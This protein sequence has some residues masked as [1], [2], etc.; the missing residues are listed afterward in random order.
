MF[1]DPNSNLCTCD[2]LENLCRL[3]IELLPEVAKRVRLEDLYVILKNCECG[4]DD[5]LEVVEE[6][7][8][9]YLC[10]DKDQVKAGPQDE[11][12]LDFPCE[13]LNDDCPLSVTVSQEDA[14][15]MD[16]STEA[17]IFAISKKCKNGIDNELEVLEE[18]ETYFLCQMKPIAK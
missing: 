7:E 3:E 13:C 16:A 4:V 8:D 17:A 2:C 1:C 18:R 9:Y 14:D 6:T 15:R 12:D 5:G 10:K 11:D